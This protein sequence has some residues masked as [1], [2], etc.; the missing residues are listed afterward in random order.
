[1]KP[2]NLYFNKYTVF[3][4]KHVINEY[5]LNHPN[6]QITRYKTKKKMELIELILEYKIM[7]Y[8]YNIPEQPK[9]QPKQVLT[10]YNTTVYNTKEQ[11]EFITKQSKNIR[12]Q[13]NAL[14]S[15]NRNIT[16]QPQ[17][18]QRNFIRQFMFSNLRGAI[19]FHGVGTGKTLTAVISSYYYLKMYPKHKVIIITPSA[20][21]YN[22][23][24][25]M[26]MYGLD[27]RD[28]RYTFKTYDQYVRSP[29][30]ATNTL[31][32]IDEVHNFRTLIAAVP[33]VGKDEE[34][35][36]YQSHSNKKGFKIQEYGIKNCHKVLL[37]TG[38]AFVN[39][40]IDI[41]NALAWIDDR[42][43]L[44]RNSFYH[45]LGSD[46][47]VTDYFSYR[48]SYFVNPKDSMSFFPE[49]RDFA[50][51]IV[52][53]EAYNKEY[54]K[55]KK[56]GVP[57]KKIK[58]EK[59]NA[60]Y[61]AERAATVYISGDD[62]IT[63]KNNY[64]LNLIKN[65]NQKF[66]IYI[67]LYDAGLITLLKT[68]KNNEIEPVV[69][70]GRENARQK[71][72]SKNKFNMYNF[73]NPNF[74]NPETTDPNLYRF[75]NNIY[76]VLII[77]KAGSEGVDTKNCNNLIMMNYVWN[78]AMSEQIIARAIRYKSHTELPKDLQYVNVYKLFLLYD[79][80]EL[81][82]LTKALDNK[83]FDFIK[84][85]NT[86]K[87]VRA[88]ANLEAKK[89][90][91][92]KLPS[93]QDLIKL[94]VPERTTM[95]SK[96][97]GYGKK[98]EMVVDIEG[99][100]TYDNLT[101]T[102]DFIKSSKKEELKNEKQAMKKYQDKLKSKDINETYSISKPLTPNIDKLLEAKLIANN[103]LHRKFIEY[104][105][106]SS[107]SQTQ[108]SETQLFLN[109]S[110]DLRMYILSNAKQQVIN[111]FMSSIGNSIRTF[112]EYENDINDYIIN[113]VNNNPKASQ[114]QIDNVEYTYY[115]KVTTD[116]L[117]VLTLK[118]DAK[119][120]TKKERQEFEKRQQYYTDPDMVIKMCKFSGIEN[121][122]DNVSILEPTAGIGSIVG[123]VIRYISKSVKGHI[124]YIDMVEIDKN[125]RKI[126]ET[127]F[128]SP[129]VNLDNQG[130]FLLYIPNKRYDYIFMNPP[131]HLRKSEVFTSRDVYDTDFIVRAFACL[132]VGGVLVAIT[133][134]KYTKD[135]K[136]NEKF[137]IFRDKNIA[138]FEEVLLPNVKFSQNIKIDIMM[139][140]ITKKSDSLDNDIFGKTFYPDVL[141]SGI[142]ILNAMDDLN[143]TDD[144]AELKLPEKFDD[145]PINEIK[146]VNKEEV[147][148]DVVEEKHEKARAERFKR[149]QADRK[150]EREE[151]RE[152]EKRERE[153]VVEEVV[154][155]NHETVSN[156]L[157]KL[158]YSSGQQKIIKALSNLKFKG[159]LQTSPILRTLQILQNFNTIPKMKSLINELMK[160]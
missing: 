146:L 41:E 129:Y 101:N 91:G 9:A 97:M 105:D 13:L 79:N 18:H 52:M 50:V 111:S 81:D 77:T 110:I 84:A 147:V 151:E 92:K 112:E 3:Q 51:P 22:F 128:K 144:D 118:N 116:M 40:L 75:N 94:G 28:N 107:T 108:D 54:S 29:I 72:E 1:M 123:P 156:E 8:K 66:I 61:S 137:D 31:L 68:L 37:L 25:S 102:I 157:Q 57:Y 43:Q 65:S 58:S 155:E 15:P 34:I 121:I 120:L 12:Y 127:N 46:A 63:V 99:M 67:T 88:L 47:S 87:E 44:D 134:T 98:N 26:I 126:L 114:N 24:D 104:T 10:N 115:K 117:K 138:T 39:S 132:K 139:L 56:D 42:K 70:S 2:S 130:N 113:F 6:K 80:R 16:I 135:E 27:I 96:R 30:I 73:N 49:R 78:E 140:K 159:R 131:F 69:I 19:L 35:I 17:N 125:N 14:I 76:R 20:L 86:I 93:V 106:K 95:K 11:E 136:E 83:N 60:F 32:I 122:K 71:Q 55:I 160:E 82:Y 5:N 149:R 45:M 148:E 85:S 59:P 142:R 103:W 62:K 109:M 90:E 23:V 89:Y 119:I 48:I 124:A 154:E 152:R 145:A 36:G 74:F 143:L 133:W 21:L 53:T 158:L 100:D 153:E 7:M 4:L 38:T 141:A 64:I 150:R 33:I